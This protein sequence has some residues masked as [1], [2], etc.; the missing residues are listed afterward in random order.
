[1]KSHKNYMNQELIFS[2]SD[3]VANL[4][5]LLDQEMVGMQRLPALLFYAPF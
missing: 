1:M 5:V 4:Q 2:S 3:N